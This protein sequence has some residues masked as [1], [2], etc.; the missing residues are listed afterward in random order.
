[1]CDACHLKNTR[2]KGWNDVPEPVFAAS[3]G[4]WVDLSHRLTPELS[5]IP[6]YPQ[7][8][9]DK[10]KKMPEYPSNIT[11]MSMVV[12][13]GTHLDAPYHFIADGPSFDQVPLNRLYGPGVVWSFCVGEYGRIDVAD[14]EKARPEVQPGDI[15]LFDTGWSKRVNDPSYTRHAS[16]TPA[17][18]E[19]LLAKRVK[20]I[21]VDFATPDLAPS[22]R[23]EGF[24]WP[25][26]HILLPHGVLIAEH[27]NNLGALSNR[28]IEAMFAGISIIDSDG[29]PVR[30]LAR[31]VD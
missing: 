28:R 24:Y 17:S 27:V 8:S 22:N 13:H 9:F 25:V 19:W 4:P 16:L 6:N 11:L 1:M 30:A 23:P 7:P 15:V 29:G 20:M 2:W 14:L 5:A 18:A 3:G 21:G 12:H 26:H 10:W 31:A